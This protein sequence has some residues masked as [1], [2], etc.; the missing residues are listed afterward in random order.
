M[1]DIGKVIFTNVRSSGT[2]RL[3]ASL[4]NIFPILNDETL[5]NSSSF[6]SSSLNQLGKTLFE[7]GDESL[8]I[9]FDTEATL[10]VL[11]LTSIK[12]LPWSTKIAQIVEIS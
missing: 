12:H 1:Q 5:K 8:A 11:N 7:I 9:L 4:F 10:S 6:Q 3:L 2:F